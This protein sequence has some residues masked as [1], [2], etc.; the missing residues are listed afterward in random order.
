MP[1][2][3]SKRRTYQPPPKAKPPSSPEWVP[4]LVFVLLIG[5]AIVIIGNYVGLFPGDT[6]NWRLWY[7]LGLV[8]ASLVVATQWH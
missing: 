2:S 4:A 7:G 1:K 8:S 3:R 5:G 6:S